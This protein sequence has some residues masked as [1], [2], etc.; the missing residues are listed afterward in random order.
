[1]PHWRR[2]DVTREA[3]LIEEVARLHGVNDQLPSTLPSRRGAVG[4][5]TPAQRLRRRAED[6]LAGR[7]LLE[8]VGWS[9]EAPDVDDRLRLPA[10]RPAPAR[11]SSSRT[12]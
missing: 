1:M 2:N 6:A 3:D 11:A 7:G 10:G 4:I 8:I 9:F 5:L 12:R